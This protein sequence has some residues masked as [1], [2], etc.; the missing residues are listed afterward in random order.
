MVHFC[1]S[2]RFK[3]TI[4]EAVKLFDSFH[5]PVLSE[6]T[7]Q[8]DA[9]HLYIWELIRSLSV[10]GEAEAQAYRELERALRIYI[11]RFSAPPESCESSS[12]PYVPA[13]IYLD[14]RARHALARVR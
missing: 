11:L 10:R 7:L 13:E 9:G 6:V 2:G 4:S 3:F 8:L 5:G 12:G 1:A 14:P